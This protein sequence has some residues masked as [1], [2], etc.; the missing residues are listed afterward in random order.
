[1]DPALMGAIIIACCFAA[2]V[3]ET[4]RKKNTSSK[5]S[6]RNL[7]VDAKEARDDQF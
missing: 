1:M 5:R 2:G 3:F 4:G 6:H 7:H